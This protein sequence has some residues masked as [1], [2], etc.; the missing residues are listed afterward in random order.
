MTAPVASTVTK[1]G[2][3]Y[4]DTVTGGRYPS[5]T[6]VIDRALSK[7]A[8]TKWY[9][10]QT[11][12]R[13]VEQLAEL[14][15]RV[16]LDGPESAAAWLAEAPRDAANTAALRG[17]DLHDLAE[18]TARGAG[19]PPDLDRDVARMLDHYE[20]FLADFSPV[21]EHAEM[22]VLNRAL[23]YG[24]TADAVMTIPAYTG[25]P[26][27]CDYKTA[28][29]GPYAEWAVQ[30]A[31][32][33]N[34]EVVLERTPNGIREAP[35]PTVDLTRALILRVR[36]DGYE[37]HEAD[38]TGLID[39]FTAMLKVHG[40]AENCEPFNRRYPEH[41]TPAYWK[42]RIEAAT[43]VD[44]LTAV[45]VDATAVNQWDNNLL[46]QCRAKKAALMRGAA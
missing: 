29:T 10:R 41:S 13:A 39:V 46:N 44:D 38:L 30:L 15:R 33:A 3:Y 17:S 19:T 7:P 11:A 14:S 9:A 21:I 37:L 28:R 32:Y 25:L 1:R 36:P 43:T 8:L 42:R 45:W 12:G 4:V 35:M 34:G 18:R 23:G 5:V 22:T 27:V 20:T 31:A 16:R 40:F 26:L 2:R 24:G 6:T